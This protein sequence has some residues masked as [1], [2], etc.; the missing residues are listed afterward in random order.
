MKNVHGWP[1]RFAWHTEKFYIMCRQQFLYIKKYTSVYY[2]VLL[3]IDLQAFFL[4]PFF[5]KLNFSTV[6]HAKKQAPWWGDLG[7]TWPFLCHNKATTL[8][9]NLRK[10][11][12]LP[13]SAD[14]SQFTYSA[15]ID[16]VLLPSTLGNLACLLDGV[17]LVIIIKS[18][19][20]LCP[21]SIF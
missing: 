15:I 9:T 6:L 14:L 3:Q 5:G 17:C 11:T 7:P 4:H 19:D 13:D 18:L 20:R 12:Q 1:F 21:Y 8:Q 16:P 2:I 10:V